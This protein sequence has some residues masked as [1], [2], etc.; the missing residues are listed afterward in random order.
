MNTNLML[1]SIGI[2]LNMGIAAKVIAQPYPTKTIR[3]VTPYTSGSPVDVLARVVAQDLSNQFGHGVIVENRPGAGT[4]IGNK[5]V[6][7]ATPDGYTLLISGT[8]NIAYTPSLYPDAGYD[9]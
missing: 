2:L 3:I 6:A 7:A 5:F 8:A 4:T 9:S 1:A